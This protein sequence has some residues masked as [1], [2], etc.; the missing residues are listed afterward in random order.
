MTNPNDA[1]SLSRANLPKIIIDLLL[2]WYPEDGSPLI[3]PEN[4]PTAWAWWRYLGKLPRPPWGENCKTCQL[5]MWMSDVAI[6]TVHYKRK[7]SWFLL[8]FCMLLKKHL[9][10]FFGL[11][12][13]FKQKNTFSDWKLQMSSRKTKRRGVFGIELMENNSLIGKKSFHP[14]RQRHKQPIEAPNCCWSSSLLHGD[15]TQKCQKI[16]DPLNYPWELAA[17]GVCF[18]ENCFFLK[19]W[20]KLE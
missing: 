7:H 4:S 12:V 5:R 16:L 15:T 1:L 10:I 6:S 8:C 17:W 3:T 2:V 9:R 11:G 18:V 20:S 13:K 14:L 19:V